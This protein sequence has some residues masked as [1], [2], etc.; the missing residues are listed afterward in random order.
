MPYCKHGVMYGSGERCGDGCMQCQDEEVEYLDRQDQLRMMEE[1]LDLQREMVHG[2]R[3][4]AAPQSPNPV[5]REKRQASGR[6]ALTYGDIYDVSG[7]RKAPASAVP[8]RA[9]AVHPLATDTSPP[10]VAQVPSSLP[11]QGAHEP[12]RDSSAPIT[13]LQVITALG[14]LGAALFALSLV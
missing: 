4:A 7:R 2:R 3:P 6:P 13:V 9:L 8:D 12:Q 10:Y 1:M 11:V 5:A 14:V